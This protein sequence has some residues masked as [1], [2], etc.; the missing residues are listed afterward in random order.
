MRIRWEERILAQAFPSEY[1]DYARR[2]PRYLPN[3]FSRI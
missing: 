1:P 3:P 2:I